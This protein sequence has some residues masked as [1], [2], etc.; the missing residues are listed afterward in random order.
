MKKHKLSDGAIQFS[1]FILCPLLKCGGFRST[2]VCRVKKCRRY[3]L[4]TCPSVA[5]HY[6]SMGY[7]QEQNKAGKRKEASK[8]KQRRQRT[9]PAEGLSQIKHQQAGPHERGAEAAAQLDS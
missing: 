3:K 7:E 9:V 6:S 1:S 4:A 5:H 2:L 8:K